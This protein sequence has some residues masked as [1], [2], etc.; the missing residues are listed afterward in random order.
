[1]SLKLK[2]CMLENAAAAVKTGVGPAST[3]E[4]HL[5]NHLAFMVEKSFYFIF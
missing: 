5:Q 4:V 2:Q 1:M 3:S